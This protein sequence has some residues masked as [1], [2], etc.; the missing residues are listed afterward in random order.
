VA[1]KNDEISEELGLGVTP[2]EN[3]DNAIPYMTNAVSGDAVLTARDFLQGISQMAQREVIFLT[4]Q[5]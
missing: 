4:Y 3:T 2:S 1:V 5:G